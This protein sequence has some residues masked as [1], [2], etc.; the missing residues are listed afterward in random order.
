MYKTIKYILGIYLAAE[1]QINN[2][3][4]SKNTLLCLEIFHMIF[5]NP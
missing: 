5:D 1:P 3:R 4:I 2:G